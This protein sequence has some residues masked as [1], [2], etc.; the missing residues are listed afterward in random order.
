MSKH[1][2]KSGGKGSLNQIQLWVNNDPNTLNQS[3]ENAIP[4]LAG[5]LIT[6]YSPL[7]S[8]SYSEYRDGDFLDVL[9]LSI[10]KSAL[11]SFWPNG[12]PQWDALAKTKSGKIILVEAKA[13]EKELKST[14]QAKA[15]SSISLI[16]NSLNEAKRHFGINPN[17]NWKVGFYQHANRL[18]HLYFLSEWCQVETYLVFIHFLDDKSVNGPQTEAEWQKALHPMYAQLG[19]ANNWPQNPVANIFIQ[20][21]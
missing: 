7:Q 5:D 11:R 18:A 9:G 3:I 12:G 20:A 16:E 10:H 21:K 19:L 2:Q 1:P 14:C 4:A 8:D 15:A 13:N 17:A 6:W